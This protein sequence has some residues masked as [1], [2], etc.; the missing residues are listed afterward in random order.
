[1]GPPPPSSTYPFAAA[2]D[3][4]RAHQKDAYFSTLLHS[5]L[6]TLLRNLYGARLAHTY[7]T[8]T[9]VTG[10]LLY[11]VLTTLLGNRTLGE[12][13]TDIVHVEAETGRLPGLGRRAGYVMACV[14]GPYVA[15]RVLPVLRKRVR[16]KL[17]GEVRR[18]G[19]QQGDGGKAGQETST[20]HSSKPLSIRFQT[21]LLD[22]LDT[23]TS[24]SPIYA[25]SLA[26]FYFSGGYY[27]LSK[28]LCRLRYIFTRHVGDT[29][30]RAG[31]EVLG[32]LLVLQMAVQ[33]Y[34]HLHSNVA[35]ATNPQPA[36]TTTTSA[37]VG[38][39]AEV[40]LDPMSY[41]PNNAL[42]PL[43]ASPPTTAAST[44]HHMTHTPA[45]TPAFPRHDLAD[46]DAMQWIS[47]Q[48]RKCTLC[49]ESMRD[50]GVT[51]CGHVFCWTCIVEW[52]A[53]KPECPLCRAVVGKSGVLVLR[54]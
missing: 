7:S 34:L 40:S 29:D 2:P 30:N 36:S 6:S 37:I 14:V 8:E 24:P 13:Y 25:L 48:N 12:E 52:V 35:A 49:L 46:S 31:Y 32:V 10:E 44:L 15:G 47:P 21:Y 53:E 33:A 1:M 43:L 38:G 20:V 5:H 23:I 51:T 19:R 3:I 42:L 50:P 28:R 16:G 11:L 41:T 54:G 4:I 17:E 45:S 26:T 18:W 27:Q 9:R 39:G 22:N